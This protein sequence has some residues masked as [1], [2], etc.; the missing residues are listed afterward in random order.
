MRTGSAGDP[1]LTALG[2]KHSAVVTPTQTSPDVTDERRTEKFVARFRR[3]DVPIT[4]AG[5]GQ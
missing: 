5:P 3:L 4:N 2:L 1:V